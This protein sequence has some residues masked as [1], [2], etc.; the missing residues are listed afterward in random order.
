MKLLNMTGAWLLATMALLPTA[1][2]QKAGNEEGGIY[3][4]GNKGSFFTAP[5][6]PGGRLSLD[7]SGFP[8]PRRGPGFG[9]VLPK[10]EPRKKGALA[11]VAKAARKFAEDMQVAQL[12]DFKVKVRI[13]FK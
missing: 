8:A 4:N 7:E 1:S 9:T 3:G 6:L 10:P 13:D 5:G 11:F 2:A 12:G